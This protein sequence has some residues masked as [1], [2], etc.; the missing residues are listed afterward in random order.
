MTAS[1]ERSSISNSTVRQPTRLSRSRMKRRHS[2]AI[3]SKAFAGRGGAGPTRSKG[4]KAMACPFAPSREGEPSEKKSSAAKG[5]RAQDHP[6]VPQLD[7]LVE[8]AIAG[9]D[10]SRCV[11]PQFR[12]GCFQFLLRAD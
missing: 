5:P 8:D 1:Q 3:S 12:P 2:S 7:R 10:A 4:Q 9:A 6:E 11:H